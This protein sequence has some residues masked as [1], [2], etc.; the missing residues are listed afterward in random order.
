MPCPGIIYMDTGQSWTIKP[1]SYNFNHN[2]TS[3]AF[4]ARSEYFLS[5][6]LMYLSPSF[7]HRIER[8]RFKESNPVK[9]SVDEVV[10][11]NG[12]FT[13]HLH[14]GWG[15]EFSKILSAFCSYCSFQFALFGNLKCYEICLKFL[16]P[17]LAWRWQWHLSALHP[18]KVTFFGVVCIDIPHTS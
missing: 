7:H 8:L 3:G 14:I 5:T 11:T 12:H 13:N 6:L 9:S 15:A 1:A 16:Q 2:S 10:L 17:K 18:S 4:G